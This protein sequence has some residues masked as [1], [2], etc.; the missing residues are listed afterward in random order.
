MVEKSQLKDHNRRDVERLK[1]VAEA[2]IPVLPDWEIKRN[3]KEL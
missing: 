2:V 1:K 3:I